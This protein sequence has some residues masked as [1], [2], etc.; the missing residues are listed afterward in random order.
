M[1]K[2]QKRPTMWQKRPITC[3]K[4][5]YHTNKRDPQMHWHTR[6]M[7]KCQKRPI[8]WQKRPST[9]QKRPTNTLAYQ[10]AAH[11]LRRCSQVPCIFFFCTSTDALF[12]SA[13]FFLFLV[14]A[15]LPMPGQ[16]AG[17]RRRRRRRRWRR[18]GKE[19]DS[20]CRG[21]GAMQGCVVYLQ[22]VV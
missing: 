12:V 4:E 13:F 9:R 7:R 10:S 5:P 11:P 21:P 2:C 3:T 18:K 19:G 6:G 16:S 1:R 17:R 20:G 15:Y 8:I 22:S 14:L